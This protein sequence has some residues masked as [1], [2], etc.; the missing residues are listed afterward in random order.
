MIE[1]FGPFPYATNLGENELIKVLQVVTLIGKNGQYG[2]PVTVSREISSAF[3]SFGQFKFSTIAG[4]LESSNHMSNSEQLIRIRKY[5]PYKSV[6]S[7]FSIEYAQTFLRQIKETDI[8]HLHFARDLMQIFSGYVAIFL[9]KPYILQTHGMIR[10]KDNFL[11]TI[12]DFVFIK[13]ILKRAK[14]ILVLTAT[15]QSELEKIYKNTRFA[16]LRNGVKFNL[17]KK[18]KMNKIY[19]IIFCAR[20]H[21]TKGLDIFI[22]IAKLMEGNNKVF[23]E[24]YGPDGGEL[25]NLIENISDQKNIVYKGALNS[26]EVAEV[27]SKSDLLIMPSYYDPYPMVVLEALSIGLPVLISKNCGQARIISQINEDYVVEGISA[28]IYLERIIK[29]YKEDFH[30]SQREKI[31]NSARIYFDSEI[32][33]KELKTIYMDVQNAR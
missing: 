10:K 7:L 32:V 17:I 13:P 33:Y 12:F 9:R 18:T 3:E 5:I 1:A 16:I 31:M 2:G 19:K 15:E 14:C 26:N 4:T 30:R 23:F 28:Q 8:V 20:L 24:V 21:K 29:L 25:A 22:E 11:V 6:S 27:L